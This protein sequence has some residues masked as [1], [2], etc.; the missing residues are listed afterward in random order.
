MACPIQF[1]GFL[2][3]G[4]SVYMRYRFGKLSA[5]VDGEQVFLEEK[6]WGLLTEDLTVEEIQEK[7]TSAGFIFPEGLSLMEVY[8]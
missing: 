7:M 5:Y 3:N 8:G 1:E 4:K 6:P 2:D